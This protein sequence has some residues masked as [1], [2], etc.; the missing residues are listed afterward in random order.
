[1]PKSW[2]DLF[3]EEEVFYGST[4]RMSLWAATVLSIMWPIWWVRNS[5][6][7]KGKKCSTIHLAE[8][9][10]SRMAWWMV[11]SGKFRRVVI[12]VICRA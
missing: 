11:G 10:K 5:R 3:N 9:I 7:F 6:I 2:L 8:V 1:M 4:F 12:S